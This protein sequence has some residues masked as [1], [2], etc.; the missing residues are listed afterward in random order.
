MNTH[1][2]TT[3]LALLLALRDLQIP[4]NA[5]EQSLLQDVGQQLVI[6]PDYWEFIEQELMAIIKANTALNNLY[7]IYKAK[8]DN[9]D[10]RLLRGILSNL[11]ELEQE[12]FIQTKEVVTFNGSSKDG[13]ESENSLLINAASRILLGENQDQI[14]KELN[15]LEKESEYLKNYRYF[16]TY[17]TEP[18][19]QTTIP[20]T[21][22]LIHGQTYYLC[23]NISP[24][25]QGIDKTFF[26]DEILAQ[27]WNDQENL[28]LDV[29]IASKD[30]N[31]NVTTKK[32]SLPR[33][34]ASDNLIFT[35]KPHKFDGRGY[36]QVELFYRGYL[37]QSKQIAVLIIP[38]VGA[39]IPESLRP[40]Q[41]SRVNFTTTHLLTND[42]LARL[43]ERFLT[44]DVQVDMQDGS[45]DLR[46]IDRTQG[47]QE[48]LSYET[49]LQSGLGSAIASVRKK[50]KA[51]TSTK[52][53]YQFKTQGDMALL[54]TWLPQ[55]ADAGR[56][57]YRSLLPENNSQTLGEDKGEKLR[58][59]LKPDSVIQINP[60]NPILG[61]GKAT[62]PWG[63]L[64]ERKVMRCNQL[65]VCEQ[66]ISHD[67]D[68]TNCPSKN[69]YKVVCPHA[70]WGYR[71][72]IEQLPAWTN[73]E[74]SQTP[75]LVWEINN[76]EPL[77][78]NFNVWRD[79]RFWKNHLPKLEQLGSVKILVAEELI[80]LEDIW[81]SHSSDLDIVYFY[82]H[83]GIDEF[84]QLPY[85]QLSDDKIYSNFIEACEVNW[86]HRPLVLLNGCAT[87]DYSPESYMSLIDD[88][89]SA[90]ASG[91]IATEC[92]VPE[93]FAEPY[94]FALLTRVFRGEPLGKAMLAVRREMLQHHLN[95]LGL[96]YSLYAPYEI[97]LARAVAHH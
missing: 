22:P 83:G 31:I 89:R 10:V 24:Q 25:P 37:L 39:D 75:N 51:I 94:A 13:A 3:L 23:I 56:S 34:G 60:I 43:P 61:L 59:A 28:F 62:I 41:S 36:I 78:I 92:P 18:N 12:L 70:F 57:L 35:L 32:L 86:Q 5:H 96:V 65:R 19:N 17:F 47:N 40:P 74:N 87:G 76:S 1:V 38:T 21:E 29:L 82:C 15:S 52:E 46:F 8:L 55:L 44:V 9:L 14:A 50:L 79:F 91:V 48:L 63:L 90:G 93:M 67:I 64:Y 80:E 68:C 30:F 97:A 42:R 73:E 95:P 66:F 11:A 54:N 6:D 69:D 58:A 72:A 53:G 33:T 16:N 4:L 27:V 45:T 26:P 85:L 81:A 77:H 88:F 49:N 71:Y 2:S 20:P 7:Q 84:E